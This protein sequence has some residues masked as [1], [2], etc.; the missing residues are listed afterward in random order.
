MSTSWL[1]NGAEQLLATIEAGPCVLVTL[2]LI[3]GS[4]PRE[5]GSRMIVA[6]DKVQGSIGGGNLEFT[7]INM[8]REMLGQSAEARQAHQPFGLGPALNQC[9][10]GAVTVHFEVFPGPDSGSSSKWG[11]TWGPERG[12]VWLWRLTH[13]PQ[14]PVQ[15]L[16]TAI[17]RN[18]PLRI[19]FRE[20][21]STPGDAPAAVRDMAASLLGA[22][23]VHEEAELKPIHVVELEGDTWWLE[24]I[25]PRLHPLALFGAGHVGVQV[26]RLLERLPFNVTW[27]DGRPDVFDGSVVQGNVLPQ[28]LEDPAAAVA[29]LAPGSVIVVMT[30]SHDLDE[31]ICFEV[32][33]RNEFA[34][35]GLIGSATKRRRFEMRLEKRGIDPGQIKRLVCPIGLAGIDGKQPATIALSLVAQLM[36][37]KPWISAS[38]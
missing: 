27:L 29:G 4:A 36:L 32:L 9:C 6:A 3:L 14:P 28:R 7:A 22:G 37:E 10:G 20:N 15:V 16:A 13:G 23:P 30:H 33:K 2:N 25:A 26:A 38:N 21:E 8:A 12:P 19:L 31:D 24:R 34:W 5:S 18:Q 35:L 11:P 17:D 1:N